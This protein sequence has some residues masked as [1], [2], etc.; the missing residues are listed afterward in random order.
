LNSAKSGIPTRQSNKLK[1]H[2][3]R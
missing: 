1:K 3:R 2:W